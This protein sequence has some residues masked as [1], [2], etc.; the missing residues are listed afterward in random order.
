V[1]FSF[2][3]VSFRLP[4][5]GSLPPGSAVLRSPLSLEWNMPMKLVA[6]LAAAGVLAL[7]ACGT[8]SHPKPKP[9]L[10]QSAASRSFL[11]G[12]KYGQTINLPGQSVGEARA[13]CAVSA[14]ENMPLGDVESSWATG[15]MLGS[16]AG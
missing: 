13:N 15:C 3:G 12:E 2:S 11:D 9:S 4:L 7:A 6:A 16:L 1:R 5:P 14:T 8:A 10:A